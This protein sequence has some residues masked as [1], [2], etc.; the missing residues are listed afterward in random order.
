MGNF[1]STEKLRGMLGPEKFEQLENGAIDK[2][3]AFLNGKITSTMNK[4]MSDK[5][6][7]GLT[8][9]TTSGLGLYST[10]SALVTNPAILSGLADQIVSS[11]MDIVATE[12]GKLGGK[13]AG[14][15][16]QILTSIPS[17]IQSYSMSY[18][19]AYK[20]SFGEMLSEVMND[21]ESNDEKRQEDSEKKSKNKT[22]EKTKKA[23][24]DAKDFIDKNT[25][26]INSYLGTITKYVEEGPD[27]LAKEIDKQIDKGV[28]YANKQVDQKIE[29]VE[30]YVNTECKKQGEKI[31]KKMVEAYNDKLLKQAQKQLA[32]QKTTISKAKALAFKAKQAGILQIMGMTGIGMP[33]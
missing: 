17:K 26:L 32:K 9:A 29:D 21:S 13:I 6:V 19:N 30:K 22:L 28:K 10:A 1:V 3:S 27:M 8:Q 16:T 14:K 5:T 24:G 20:K 18:F 25:K 23:L 11:S 12:L 33:I 7:V 4:V 2:G 15:S 31:G